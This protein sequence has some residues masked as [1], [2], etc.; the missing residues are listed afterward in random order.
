MG[1]MHET[2]APWRHGKGIQ[3]R[4]RKHTLQMGFCKRLQHTDKT[5]GILSAVGGRML[6]L[7]ADEI[8]NW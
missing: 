2:G 7:E 6:D 1:F 5:S 3:L 4:T 8:G